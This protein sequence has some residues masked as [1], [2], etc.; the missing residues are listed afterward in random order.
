MSLNYPGSE[1]KILITH[2]NKDNVWG[3]WWEKTRNA[4]FWITALTDGKSNVN[5]EV[6]IFNSPT[7]LCVNCLFWG[8]GLL[9]WG[10]CSFLQASLTCTI[11]LFSKSSHLR[12][13]IQSRGGRKW[14]CVICPQFSLLFEILGDQKYIS[15]VPDKINPHC[16]N[17]V[18]QSDTFSSSERMNSIFIVTKNEELHLLSRGRA[19]ALGR[20]TRRVCLVS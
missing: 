20:E 14:H 8:V 1:N 16:I 5:Y 15:W 7:V 12:M 18:I 9:F 3:R 13:V 19:P 4:S 11:V 6:V 17:K 2:N 10:H